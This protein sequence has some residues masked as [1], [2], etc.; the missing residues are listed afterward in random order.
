MPAG[1][2]AWTIEAA[3]AIVSRIDELFG[4]PHKL[5]IRADGSSSVSS[6]GEN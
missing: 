3:S 6:S 4:P 5:A 1:E 2:A